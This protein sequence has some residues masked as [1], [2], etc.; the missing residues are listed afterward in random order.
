MKITGHFTCISENIIHCISSRKYPKAIYIG[1]TG[2]KLADR[3]REH[4]L[5]VLHNKGDLPVAQHF[6]CPNHSLED[7]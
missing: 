7:K 5:D 6:N 2:R 1:E 3:F 4:R